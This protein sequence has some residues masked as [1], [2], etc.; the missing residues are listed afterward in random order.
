MIDGVDILSLSV[1][2]DE[3]PEEALT[4]LALFE[5]F[6]LAAHRAG[7]FVVQAAGNHGPGPYSVIS[8]SPWSVGVAACDTDRSFPGTLILSDGQKISGIGLSGTQVCVKFRFW[9]NST[10]S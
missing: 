9:L 3:P 8:Y 5:I 2:P 7:V 1:G 10:D 4:F 6:M